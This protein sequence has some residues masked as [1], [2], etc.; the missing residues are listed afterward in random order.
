[1]QSVDSSQSVSS[2]S[3]EFELT[4]HLLIYGYWVTVCL[5]CLRHSEV[6]TDAELEGEQ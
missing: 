3:T 2:S 4:K 1:M 5:R 6:I